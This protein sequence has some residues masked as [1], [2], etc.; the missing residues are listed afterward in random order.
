MD[1]SPDQQP[2]TDEQSE[3]ARWREVVRA[4]VEMAFASR[5]LVVS[6][7]VAAH[8]DVISYDTN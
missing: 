1:T 2:P 6:Q 8:G 4:S 5:R 7:G 3:E